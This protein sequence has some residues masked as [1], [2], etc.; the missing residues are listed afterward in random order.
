MATLRFT[1][2][3]SRHVDCPPQE[4]DG[5]SVRDVLEAYFARHPRVRGYVVDEQGHLRR[6][7][8]VFIDGV[9][10]KDR[11]GLTDTVPP[12]AELYV[13]QALSGG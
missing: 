6:H 11:K 12:S 7:V 10:A 3:L 5:G 9:Q 2:Q 1:T 13:M 8:V 4:V